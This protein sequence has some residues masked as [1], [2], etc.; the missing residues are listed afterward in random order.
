MGEVVWIHEEKKTALMRTNSLFRHDQAPRAKMNQQRSRRFRASKE[1]VELV[2]EKSRIREEII[3]RGERCLFVTSFSSRC[4]TGFKN[5][6][7]VNFSLWNV[8]FLFLA[9]MSAFSGQPSNLTQTF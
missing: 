3:Q 7:G 2:E 6:P 9:S 8:Q 1:G 4:A 5:K